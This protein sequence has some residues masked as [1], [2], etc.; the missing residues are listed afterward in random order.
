MEPRP[1]N[2]VI[3]VVL[4]D[5][6]ALL[7]A[8][9]KSELGP[10]FAVVGEADDAEGAIDVVNAH[11]P[12]LVVTDLHM[13]R[14]GGLAVV[15]ACATIAPIVILTVSEAERDLLDAEPLR[16]PGDVES[17]AV[18]AHAD[19]HLSVVV[20]LGIDGGSCRLGVL[21]RVRHRFTGSSAQRCAHLIARSAPVRIID[22]RHCDRLV[23]V[24]TDRVGGAAE[25][26]FEGAA[27]VVGAHAV[28]QPG[29]QLTI[30][31]PR[32]CG[33]FRI[34]LVDATINESQRLQHTIVERA[35][36]LI[37]RTTE[38]DF[39]LGGS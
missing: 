13:P 18:I 8:G 23:I 9:L 20:D 6:H 30:A 38:C 7:R 5:D 25:T 15:R 27:V 32:H 24:A 19:K 35:S 33:Q 21:G 16:G 1:K 29:S 17:L 34:R 37:T 14:G 36:N 4:A 31:R 39:V 28:K 26:L 10:G 12:D 22:D 2:A 3:R 11:K